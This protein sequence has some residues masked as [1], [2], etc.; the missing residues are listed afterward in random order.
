MKIKKL[1][2]L[3]SLIL[4]GLMFTLPV[5]AEKN[6]SNG[7]HGDSKHHKG[8]KEKHQGGMHLFT[9]NWHG[10]LTDD[11]KLQVDGMHLKLMKETAT[12]KAGIQGGKTELAI[13]ATR[14]QADAKAINQKIDE[15]LDLKRKKMQK[16][17]EHIVEMRQ[18][19]SPE[20][21]L[22]FDMMIVSRAGKSKK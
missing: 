1:L 5:S 15:I 16:R 2:I 18:I 17:Y 12:I 13:L 14:N 21:R 7:E 4:V 6:P 10:T 19:L 20:Q 8:K 22:S 9:E 3:L 11:Q